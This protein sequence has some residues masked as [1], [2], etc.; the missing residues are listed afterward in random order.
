MNKSIAKLCR[1][2]FQLGS[3][4][5]KVS[6]TDEKF[7]RSFSHLE[8]FFLFDILWFVIRLN[9][10]KY[11]QKVF[12]WERIHN[13]GINFLE[14]NLRERSDM[15]KLIFKKFSFELFEIEA[16]FFFFIWKKNI[17]QKII[18][19]RWFLNSP[20]NPSQCFS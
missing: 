16:Q 12:E 14:E 19:Q 7:N 1:K 8:Y 11:F 4:L 2:L 13:F 3:P 5:F 18:I 9:L 20:I 17:L 15:V 10:I 6:F